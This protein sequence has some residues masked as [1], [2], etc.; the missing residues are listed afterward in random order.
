VPDQE[1][2]RE[3]QAGDLPGSGQAGA[4]TESP[5]AVRAV[6]AIASEDAEVE[7][8]DDTPAAVRRRALR[9]MT[10]HL[11]FPVVAFWARRLDRQAVESFDSVLAP[12]GK[13]QQL[14][15]VIN[16]EG[17]DP[18][19][20]HLIASL[21]HEYTDHLHVYVAQA[22]AS[23]A[24]LLALHAHTLWMGRTS[25][26]SPIDPQ[27]EILAREMYPEDADDA[28]E[29]ETILIPG[30]VLQDFLELVGVIDSG[31]PRPRFNLEAIQPLL[32]SLTV[33]RLGFYERAEKIS[34]LYAREA[35]VNYLLRDQD[36]KDDKATRIVNDLMERFASHGAGIMRKPARALGIPV[37]DTPAEIWQQI[38][39]LGEGYRADDQRVEHDQ[40]W[41]VETDDAQHAP[42][43]AFVRCERCGTPAA[44]DFE[45]RY[46]GECGNPLWDECAGCDMVPGSDWKFCRNCGT[47]IVRGV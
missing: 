36:D 29:D 19:A 46:C 32:R 47:S 37:S 22:A 35:L 33:I 12:L 20:A 41:T 26:L 3:D 9:A 38:V 14:A 11:G 39:A 4:G 15:V 5:H 42:A 2:E 45:L 44:L 18:D 31:R 25:Q 23:A 8:T 1:A 43:A 16:S 34:R 10:E 17:G 21:L 30:R 13:Q 28:W 24:T 40:D 6:P 7:P 27:V